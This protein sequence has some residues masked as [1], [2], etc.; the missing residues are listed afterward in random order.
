MKS[1]MARTPV[2]PP[3]DL[4][5]VGEEKVVFDRCPKPN[6]Y[7]TVVQSSCCSLDRSQKNAEPQSSQHNWLLMQ[8]Q[9]FAIFV[10]CCI[11]C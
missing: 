6:R 4:G 5:T 3:A 7:S 8:L 10:T 9:P 2:F 1:N 11:V